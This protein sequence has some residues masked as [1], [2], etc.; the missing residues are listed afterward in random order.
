MGNDPITSV[1]FH[2]ITPASHNWAPMPGRRTLV[3]LLWIIVTSCLVHA[4]QLAVVTDLANQTTNV[5]AAELIRLF[6]ARVRNW[7]DGKPVIIVLRDPASVDME[8]VLRKVFNMTPAQARSFI[9]AHK[10]SIIVAGSD[11]AVLRF[12]ATNRGAVGI[13]DLYSLTKGVKV[14]KI[15]GKLPVE[16][17]YLLRGN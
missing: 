5:S 6:N 13:V 10:P 8:L 9:Q 12:V 11:E 15:D 4:K 3:F 7:T 14:V 17:G 16:Q 2:L 1:I